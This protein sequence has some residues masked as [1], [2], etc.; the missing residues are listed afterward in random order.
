MTE[1]LKQPPPTGLDWP[2]L[3]LDAW[4]ETYTTLH[5]WMQVVGKVRLARNPML[6]HWWQVTLY[7]TCRGLTTAPMPHGSQR[8]QIDFDFNDHRLVI[9]TDEGAQDAFALA[10]CTVADFHQQ[11]MGRLRA[12]GLETRIWTT[13][14]EM[15]DPIP[16]EADRIHA[17][18]DP[19]Y[20]NRCWRILAQADRVL[21]VFRSRFLGKASPVHLFW[22]AFDIAATRFSGRRAP[23]HPGAPGLADHVTQ[24]AY[25]HEVSS[26][27]FWPGD[28]STGGPAFYAYAYPEPPGFA[29]AEVR[30]DAAF[31]SR[32]KG[33][34]L[35][36]YDAVRQAISPDDELLAFLQDTYVAAADL[37]H[38][39]RSAL[40][41]AWC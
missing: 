28:T 2:S 19:E 9:Q 39:N 8:F 20:A 32:E 25:S 16:F 26:C 3:P 7:V 41:R 21:R 5:R 1:Q 12:M 14:V 27:G 23:T 30:P 18:Y 36:P 17:C 38:W 34:F 40:E 4:A 10:P 24:E 37:G 6:N 15:A 33:E 11:V 35:L 13:P 31:Y 29:A 22:G